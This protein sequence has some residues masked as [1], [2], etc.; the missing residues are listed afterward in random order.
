MAVKQIHPRITVFAT[1]LFLLWAWPA[2]AAEVALTILHTNDLHQSLEPLPRIAGY[3]A[4]YKRTHPNTLF[5]DA[6]DFF[7]RG[8]P[9]ASV[10]L[11][12]AMYGAMA[13]MG[14]DAWIVGNHDW[15][16]GDLR[17]L[18]LMEKYPVPV[19]GANLATVSPPLPANVLRTTVKDVAGVRVGLFGITQDSANKGPGAR[20]HLYVTDSRQ[21]AAR[22][23]ETL[24]S[25]KADLI[26][27]VTHLGLMKMK[28]EAKAVH[29]SDPDLVRA[30]PEINVVIGGHTH[31]L[32][33][34]EAT[35]KLYV[36]TGAI[37]VQSGAMGTHIGRLTLYFNDKDHHVTRFEVENVPVTSDLPEHPAVAA[38]L[39]KQYAQYMPHAKEKVG[40]FT[41]A[42]EFHNLAYWYADFIQEQAGADVA[43]LPRKSLYDEPTTFG[44]GQVSLERLLGCLHNRYLIK[45]LVS[46]AELLNFCQ[47]DAVRDRFNPFHHG[48]GFFSGD[49]IF[50]SGMTVTF[51]P[52]DQSVKFDLDANKQYVLVTPWP[53]APLD[54]SRYGRRLPER[55]GAS[56]ASNPWYTDPVPGLRVQDPVLLPKTT[57]ELLE[58]TGLN[59]GLKFYR[60][61]PA[62]R[63]DW[64]PWTTYFEAKLPFSR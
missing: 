63:P 61:Y 19:L 5:L 21:T 25:D 52:A 59:G 47:S 33:S 57:W 28:Q 10:T 7:D 32:L 17:L 46:G 22:A 49:A 42:I 8:S 58:S 53:F 44:K 16:Y 23:I 48:P 15:C 9:V 11:G 14:Y 6:G 37:I 20:P 26:V 39:R 54:T 38:F 3:V 27:A 62:P 24:K 56:A 41:E 29:P 2:F 31:T 35:R 64:K 34:E 43:F 12:E 50:Y 1:V 40:E 4:E 45:S 60:K 30:F 13:R 18:A 55:D 51:D 36:Q